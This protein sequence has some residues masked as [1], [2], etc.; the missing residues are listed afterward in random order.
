MIR[1]AVRVG[2]EHAELVLAELLELAPA[3]L[4]ERTLPDGSVEYAIYG[5]AGELPAL[6]DLRAAAG[7]ALVEVSTS[8][9]ADGWEERWRDWHRPLDVDGRAGAIRVRPPW[10]GLRP[11]AHDVV[12]DPGQAFGTGAHPTTRLCLQLLVDLAPA[13]AL[14]DWGCG[15]GILSIAAAKLGWM[16]VTA[17]DVEAASVGATLAAAELNGVALAV[18][19]R[20]LRRESGPWAP[21]VVANLV[22]PLLLEVAARLER[23][24][25]R[26]VASGLRPDEV[27][28][29]AAAF[30]E[31]GLGVA[32]RR[33]R[34]GWS[35][36]LLS[37]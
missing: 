21:T 14:A 8:E 29:V 30:A 6:P 27:D 28:A 23:V 26:L 24:P 22:R 18:D 36:I 4:E 20:D 35:A 3:G 32:Q 13:G 17:C 2:A 19:R 11:G 9:L 12:I 10:A 7:E 5:A 37:R 16:P 25:E 15:S 33:D 34:D 31:H 1:L